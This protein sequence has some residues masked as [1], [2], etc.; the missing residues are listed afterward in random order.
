MKDW[1]ALLAG[2]V[3]RA[4]SEG[5]L[6]TDA[7]PAQLAFELHSLAMGANWAFQLFGETG[8]FHRARVAFEAR[9]EPLAIGPARGRPSR[10]SSTR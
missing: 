5:H 9:L 8:A 6:R 1:L 7:D 2:A 10:R 4:Q 3:R